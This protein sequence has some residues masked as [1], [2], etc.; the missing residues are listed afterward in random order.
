MAPE[1][2]ALLV[3]PPPELGPLTRRSCIGNLL[4]RRSALVQESES[5][6]SSGMVYS[7]LA[8]ASVGIRR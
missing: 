6:R 4:L 7:A 8:K 5:E 2:E 1:A 3:W